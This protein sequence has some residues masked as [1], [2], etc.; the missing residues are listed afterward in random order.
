[1]CPIRRHQ[2]PNGSFPLACPDIWARFDKA[3]DRRNRRSS[4]EDDKERERDGDHG[5]T[6]STLDICSP[7]TTK[8][9][10]AQAGLDGRIVDAPLE[11]EVLS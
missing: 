8:F 7:F 4:H 2:T 9:A 11:E 5:Q 10:S 3:I 1:M 6:R